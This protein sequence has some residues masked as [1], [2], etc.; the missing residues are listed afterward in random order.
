MRKRILSIICIM[1]LVLGLFT[2]CGVSS[3]EESAQ[4]ESEI[5]INTETETENSEVSTETEDSEIGNEDIKSDNS[6]ISTSHE[7]VD[8][9]T[10]IKD[11]TEPIQESTPEQEQTAEQNSNPTPEQVPEPEPVPE[12]VSEPEPDSVPEQTPSG[13]GSFGVWISATGT[14]YHSINNCGN[15]NPDNAT[16][17]TEEQAIGMGYGKCSKCW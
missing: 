13:G 1:G 15:M 16:Q 12:Q 14:K 10:F 9:T 11:D 6:I 4:K 5:V 2:S 3:D 8:D 7:K 17:L